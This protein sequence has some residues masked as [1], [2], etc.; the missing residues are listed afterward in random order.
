MTFIGRVLSWEKDMAIKND[1][2]K[3]NVEKNSTVKKVHVVYMTHFDM[4]FT[5]FAEN[6][7]ENYR[8]KFIPGAVRLAQEL[9]RDGKKRFLWTT[10]AFLIDWYLRHA[11]EQGREMLCE[12]IRR[13]DISWHGL[14]FTTHTELMDRELMEFDLDYSDRLD[15]MFSK[16]TIAAKLT[17]VPGHTKA[18]IQSMVKHGKK[19]L[20]VGVNPSSM[21]PEVPS[22][23]LWKSGQ[24]EILVQYSPVYGSACYVEEMEQVLEFFFTGD[25]LGIPSKQ[26]VLE[27]LDDLER[28]Y[29][30]AEIIAST[31]D[32]YA[33][34]VWKYKN[35]LP[36]VWEEI[37]DTWI[38]G[39]ASDPQKVMHLKR[40]LNLKDQWIR[41]GVLSKSQPEYIAFMEKLLM[42]CEH[43]WGQDYKKYLF[44]FK[45]W[46]KEDFYRAR[47]KDIVTE[48]AFTKRNAALLL[49]VYEEK[50]C[51]QL[52]GSY[53]GY[54]RSWEEQR[55]YIREAKLALPETLQKEVQH[56]YA[57]IEKRME[58]YLEEGE[59]R[60]PFECIFIGQ[61]KLTFDG[62]GTMI[63]LEKQGKDW[64]KN[65][66]FGR[67]SYE[68][69]QAKDMVSEYYE[70]NH[71]FEENCVWSEADFTKPG[72]ET[73]ED[74]EHKNY[75]FSVT[76][77]RQKGNMVEI[78]LKG[79]ERAVA[80]YGCPAKACI[81][82]TFDEKIICELIWKQKDANKLPEA[83]WF[84]MQL[85]VENPYL[86]EMEIMG[87]R[88]SP[89]HV[90][91]GGNRR[92]HCTEKLRYDGA[93]GIIEIENLD[94]PLVSV[95]G[96][97]LYGGCR[98][99]PDLKKGFSYCLFNNKWGTNFPM[100]CEEDGYFTYFLSINNK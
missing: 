58:I 42:V 85:D 32:E 15:K 62:N 2:L 61:W 91:R 89:L 16:E 3:N 72:M 74:L 57:S 11:D 52:T 63:Y 33:A 47:A 25:N 9:N 4:G 10:G 97:R 6:V 71:A 95:G 80:R 17:D 59:K 92:Q 68:T 1:K 27:F 90:V 30:N 100:W 14:A 60:H 29:P 45:N 79:D 73:V 78:H 43:T 39:V 98:E 5:D 49:A 67:L 18:M 35:K 54:E 23:F 13:G 38:H 93:D 66:K 64:I 41:R 34:Q 55:N 86:W 51:C 31:L 76:E 65:G 37:G 46:E 88:I 22:S 77:I 94:S 75:V 44:D 69:Y 36:V 53:S 99:F 87:E 28:K 12:G 83:L 26:Q 48:E 19:Y 7:L 70:Y 8:D 81:R 84:D 82:Y 24:N 96:R 56:M 50:G 40:L 20:H 21:N